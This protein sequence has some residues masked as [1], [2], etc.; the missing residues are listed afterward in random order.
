VV[1]RHRH[2]THG[3]PGQDPFGGAKDPISHLA[4]IPRLDDDREIG[5]SN[6]QRPGVGLRDVDDVRALPEIVKSEDIVQLLLR[7][8]FEGPTSRSPF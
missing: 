8:N 4:P 1:V 2:V 5:E 3:L 7:A 6:Q